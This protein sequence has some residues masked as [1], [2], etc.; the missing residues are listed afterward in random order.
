MQR[1]C[2]GSGTCQPGATSSCSPYACDQ[3]GTVCLTSCTGTSDCEGTNICISTVC[4]PPLPDGDPCTTDA[5]CNSGICQ[6]D[7]GVC[8]NVDCL[9][10]CESCL[11]GDT[12]GTTGTCA[13]VTAGTDPAVEC[14]AAT[15][16][17]GPDGTGCNG[18]PT[19]PHCNGAPCDCDEQ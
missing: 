10:Q 6:D 3:N 8:C 5:H 11:T 2:D 12:G 14:A 17:C 19:D 13:A 15:G 7:D 18:S 16:P 1:F 4:Q 9:G